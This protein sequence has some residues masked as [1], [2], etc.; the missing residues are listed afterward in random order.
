MRGPNRRLPQCTH[1]YSVLRR[2]GLDRIH[3]SEHWNSPPSVS[4][5][6]HATTLPRRATPLQYLKVLLGKEE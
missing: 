4:R 3:E 2:F 5:R 1:E 6:R